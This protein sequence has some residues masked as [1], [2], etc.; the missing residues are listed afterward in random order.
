[1]KYLVYALVLFF[2]SAALALAQPYSITVTATWEVHP[3]DAA[4]PPDEW[5]LYGCDKPITG[6]FSRNLSDNSLIGKCDGR[7][8]AYRIPGDKREAVK[9][10]EVQAKKGTTYW[11]MSALRVRD[12]K[13]LESDLGEQVTLVYDLDD[14]DVIDRGHA[15]IRIDVGRV[16]E[17]VI[18]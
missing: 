13:Q 9:V 11:R 3:D 5:I 15:P 18:R 1:M 7:L 17:I 16:K 8:E 4:S 10:Y 14:V 12:G 6:E 2:G